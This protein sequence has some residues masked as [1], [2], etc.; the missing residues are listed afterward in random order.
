MAFAIGSALGRP[1]QLLRQRSKVGPDVRSRVCLLPLF[2]TP[3]PQPAPLASPAHPTGGPRCPANQQRLFAL[4]YP[5]ATTRSGRFFNRT[6]SAHLW[7]QV[8]QWLHP[9]L[10]RKRTEPSPLPAS[11]VL[12]SGRILR[13]P[14]FPSP[15]C[16]RSIRRAASGR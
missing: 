11:P 8:A 5:P 2:R 15:S 13:Q 7:S 10:H 14:D 3:L 12:C 16:A 4:P 1:V 9:L 6:R